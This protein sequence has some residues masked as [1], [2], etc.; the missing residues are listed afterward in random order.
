MQ[1]KD[2]MWQVRQTAQTAC[3][4]GTYQPSTGASSCINAGKGHYVD[5]SATTSQIQC[6]AG[7]YNPNTGSTSIA[8]CLNASAGHYVSSPGQSSES[9]CP[10]GRYQLNTVQALPHFF[11]RISCS[12]KRFFHSN[13]MCSRKIS[14]TKDNLLSVHKSGHYTA[15]TGNAAQ[16]PCPAGKYQPLTGQTSCLDTDAGHYTSARLILSNS[17]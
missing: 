4:V 16:T 10:A 8:A 5:S 17:L 3:T 2:I 11:S 6:N 13:T 12:S 7:T 9:S 14:Q 1:D 15:N